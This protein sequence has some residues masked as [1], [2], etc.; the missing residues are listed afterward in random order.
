VPIQ[1]VPVASPTSSPV[2]SSVASLPQDNSLPSTP[3]GGRPPSIVFNHVHHDPVKVSSPSMQRQI[4][5]PPAEQVV[6]AICTQLE[7]N[8]SKSSLAFQWDKIIKTVEEHAN[9]DGLSAIE[10]LGEIKKYLEDNFVN[11]SRPVPP[12]IKSK[13]TEMLQKLP[14]EQV[15]KAAADDKKDNPFRNRK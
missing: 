4:P 12:N 8:K 14:I 1:T 11:N 7:E 10:K 3:K 13:I 5:L 9:N 15:L 6:K 2:I